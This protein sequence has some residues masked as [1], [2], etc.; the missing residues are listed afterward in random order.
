M[1]D[2][3]RSRWSDDV[4]C[5]KDEM[6]MHAVAGAHGWAVF[7]LAD[8]TPLDHV[9]YESWNHAVKAAKWN[10]D[11]YMYLEIQ[12]DGMTY[13]GAHAVLTYARVISKMGYRI[14]SP[15]WQDYQAT[16][17]PLQRHDRIRAARQLATGKPIYPGIP[18]SNLPQFRKV[19]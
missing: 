14:P 11:N 12:P 10:R 1:T 2:A 18:Y 7:A 8:G 9:P 15:E 3:E 6:D 13:K 19:N 4:L 17:M 16:S 5:V